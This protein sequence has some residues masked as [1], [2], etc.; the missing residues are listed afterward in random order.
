MKKVI[1]FSGALLM[2]ACAS[3]AL[4]EMKI[5]VVDVNKILATVPQVKSMQA[6]L[7]KKFDPRGQEVVNMQNNLRSDME[8]YRQNNPSKKEDELKKEQ[9][10][11]LEESKKLQEVRNNFQR[12]LIAAQNEALRPI[13]QQIENIVSKISQEQKFDL[14]VAKISTVYNHPR[15]DITEQI[16]T[17]MNKK[18]ASP[19]P[20]AS[21]VISNNTV[22]PN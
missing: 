10:R 19:T 20:V 1:L 12:D 5:G 3:F 17:E 21:K 8:K 16:I 22:K 7:K 13:L 18:P 6:D 2:L 14:V 9:Q 15:L 4:A 11:L